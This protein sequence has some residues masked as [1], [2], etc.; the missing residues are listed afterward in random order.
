DVYPFYR[1]PAEIR[2]EAQTLESDGQNL[3]LRSGMSLN[4]SIKLRKRRV[5]TFF[6]DL[7]VDK[8]DSFRSGS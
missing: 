5:I 7:F 8:A 3:S 4:A 2:L 6:T 1:F